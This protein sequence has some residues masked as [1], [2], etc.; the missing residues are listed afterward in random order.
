MLSNMRHIKL[1]WLLTTVLLCGELGILLPSRLSA[2]PADIPVAG[3]EVGSL[4]CEMLVNP[5][6]IDV[7][8]PRLSWKIAANQR[9]VVQTAYQVIVASTP[10]KLS[11]NNGDIWNSGKV[12][13]AQSIHVRYEGKALTS[14]TACYWKVKVFTNKGE[15]GWSE[16]AQWTMG[17]LSPADWKAKW[18]GYDKASPWDSVSQ[19]SRLS[20][21]YFRKPF[22]SDSRVKKATVYMVGLG[23]YELYINGGKIGDAVLAPNPTDYRKSVLYNT[24]DVTNRIQKGENVIAAVLGNGRYFT[25]RQDYKPKKINT[26]GYPKL[27][28]QLEIDYTDGTRKTIISD[29]RWKLNVDGPIRTNNEYD[30]EE[31]DATKEL[32]NWNAVN[33]KDAGWLKPQLVKA[34]AGKV[35][36]QMSAPM[37]V[38]KVIQPASIKKVGD[39]KYI[40]DMGQNFA[41]WIKMQ[42]QGKRGT[43]VQLRFA[44]SLQ[45]N[46]ELYTANLRDAKVTD[47]YTLKGEGVESWQP[48]FVYHGFRY[49]EIAGYPGKPSIKDFEGQVV[50]DDLATTG[51]FHTSNETINRIWQNAWWGIA[52]NYKG[53][54]VD[55]PQRNERQPWLGDRATG[56]LGESFLFDNAAL[57]AKWLNDIQ[58]S[59][60]AEGA[61]PDVAPAFWNYY[62]DNV[63]WPG[64]YILVANMLYRQYGDKQ[65]VVKHYPSMKKWMEYMEKKYLKNN[66]LTKDKYGDWCVPPESLELIKSRDSLRTTKGELIA[67][68]YYYHLLQ[69]MQQFARLAGKDADIKAYATLAGKMKEAFNNRFYHARTRQYDNNT[70]TANLLPLYFGMVPDSAREAVFNHIY[71]KTRI[72]NHMHISTGVIGTQWLMRGLTKYGRSDIAYTLASNTTYPSWGYMAANGAT[73]IWE[74]WNGNTANPQMNSQNH[75]M[76]L[77]DLLTWLYEDL[78]GIRSD[79]QQVAF[80][81]IIMKPEIVDGLNTVHATYQSPYGE[82]VSSW[83]TDNARSRLT[84]EIKVP[85]NTTALVYIPAD[86]ITDVTEGGN[87]ATQSEGVRFIKTDGRYLVFETGSGAYQFEAHAGFKQGIIKDEFIFDRA[88]FPESHAATIAETPKGLIAAWFGGTKEGN[89]DVCIWTSRLENGKWTAPQMVADGI[90]NDT[91][92]FPCYNPVLYQAPDGELLL[93]Y[94]IGSRVATWKG[95][96]KRSKDNGFTWGER[97]YLPEG[98][99]GPVKNK[100]ILLGNEL[101]CA[102]STEGNGWKVH[103]EVTTDWGKTWRKIGPINDGKTINAIQPSILTYKD[104]RLQVLCRSRN[105]AVVESWS[106]DGG[107]TWSA[108]A[109]TSL[110]NNN[111]GTDAVT[112]KDGRQLLVY[113]HVLPPG[114]LAKGPRTPLNVAISE[115]GKNWSAALVLEDSPISQY[116]YPSVIQTADGMVHIVYTW[117]RELVK[118]VMIDPSKL[119]LK[120]IV[121]GIW[122]GAKSSQGKVSED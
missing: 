26:F 18:I 54:P 89:K 23:L 35:V 43:A 55:C 45:S 64:V 110:P 70:V 31:Y 7:T 37:R 27:L 40:L 109:L 44:E 39:S 9:G 86:T 50:Y 52:S 20:A 62:S 48:S 3:V 59:Q 57:Y 33:Y 90:I 98:F 96:M 24:Y 118:H 78:A 87:P 93:F 114:T 107:K 6:G 60:T 100:P 83:K 88:S 67:S 122:P 113:N 61:I 74:L 1:Y 80:K 108:M 30:G 46:G 76:L 117:R 38:M 5:Q 47:V 56:A 21:R 103:F 82:I 91:T 71:T 53:M 104:G 84:W 115:D 119:A 79:D 92:R 101:Y 8:R 63:T 49:V 41:G 4:Q 68:A 25:M 111:S 29:E 105:R 73:T 16:P 28:L 75:V 42:V 81:K 85:A 121:N 32:T 102:S 120:P 116:S 19:F 69:L 77:G 14:R 15:T 95:Y 51:S 58:Q 17:L 99:L 97:E 34:P 13:S 2:F 36:A 11:A 106:A 12:V 72:E 94:K 10:E 112:L 22:A 65:S 66:I